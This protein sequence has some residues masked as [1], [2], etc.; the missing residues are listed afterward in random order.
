MN[1]IDI[2]KL[3]SFVA[4]TLLLKLGWVDFRYV[5][6]TKWAHSS[7]CAPASQRGECEC[8]YAGYI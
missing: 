1:L 4:L 7:S 3:D 2:L 5:C 6:F 8:C